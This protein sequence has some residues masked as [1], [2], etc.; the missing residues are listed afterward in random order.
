MTV[1]KLLL[2][3]RRRAAAAPQDVPRGA[4]LK[5]AARFVLQVPDGDEVD[6]NRLKALTPE[7]VLRMDMAMAGSGAGAVRTLRA[8]VVRRSQQQ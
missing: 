3:I 8:A 7:G 2:D 4:A 5:E 1:A 6:I